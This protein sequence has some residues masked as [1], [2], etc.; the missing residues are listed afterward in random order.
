MN[1]T[2]NPQ[3]LSRA[4]QAAMAT[5]RQGTNQLE[6]HGPAGGQATAAGDPTVTVGLGPIG[7]AI[8]SAGTQAYVANNS[9]TTISV[10]DT[11]TLAVTTVPGF[12]A[13]LGVAVTP[14]GARVLVTNGDN[15]LRIYDTGTSTVST[16]SDASFNNPFEVAVNPAGTRAYVANHGGNTVSVIDLTTLMPN[17]IAT[18][19]VGAGPNGVAVK[20]D[21]SQ[22][23]VTDQNSNEVTV[24]D[25]DGAV[26]GT[27]A[28]GTVGSVPIG[29]AFNPAG[30]RAYVAGNGSGALTVL[31]ATATP[32]TQITTIGGL[33]QPAGVAVGPDGTRAYV[34]N[35][36][37]DTLSVV[38]T[39]GN[40]LITSLPVGHHPS[41]VALTPDGNFAYVTDNNDGNPPGTVSILQVRPIVTGIT[42][43]SGTTLGGDTITITGSGFTG[44]TSVTLNSSPVAAFTVVDDNTIT[45]TTPAHSA[46][47][48]QATVTTPLGSGT[49][50][51]FTFAVPPPTLSG[52]NP[53]SG[54]TSGGTLVV[55]TGTHLTGATAVST[56]GAAAAAF[57]VVD[58]THIAAVTSPHAA[59]TGP[60][61]VTTPGGTVSG[62]ITYTYVGTPPAISG[63]VPTSGSTA[64]GTQVTISGTGFTG[65]TAVT[66]AGVAAASFQ[67][68]NDTTIVAVTAPHAPV[69]G[70]VTVTTPS[71]TGVSTGSYTYLTPAPTITGIFPA[72]G[73][74]GA[75]TQVSISGTGLSGATS[76]TVDGTPVTFTVVSDNQIIATLPPHASGTVTVAVNTP[77]G[78]AHI[79]FTYTGDRT[80]L[81]A[82]P[83]LVQLFPPQTYSGRLTATLTD[84]D[85]GQ[86][87]A[88]QPITFTTGSTTL[89][90]S[91]ITNAQGVAVCNAQASLALIIINNGY[92]ATYAGN[93][94][95][96]PATAHGPLTA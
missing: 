45:A 67:V 69:S 33:S 19:G 1:T 55:I 83:A 48:V 31:D 71:G 64:G 21:G 47:T 27:T 51:S 91:A 63:F 57:Q 66:I 79:G 76:V 87:I 16:F 80:R 26:L 20:P 7:V 53:T 13:P 89:C 15:T 65:A 38:D 2:L 30:T 11:T 68:V 5:A 96:Q 44:A 73:P 61:S 6:A 54:P 22:V 85:T 77:S 3:E 43:P 88:G 82:T 92:T 90:A 14:D 56:D 36:G 17:V 23:Y 70:P 93:A 28:P 52:I 4:I 94:N 12:S 39:V 40:S 95:H 49:G 72:Q 50:G 62:P 58:D 32:P 41:R 8:N 9:D 59:G 24:L 10:I 35:F 25:P 18:P 46:G 74:A 29:V 84:L 81:T 78:S 86:P 75:T 42:P 37:A 34:V 60:V